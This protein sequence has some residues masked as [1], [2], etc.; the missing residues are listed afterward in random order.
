MSDW[1]CNICRYEEVK[2]NLPA[3]WTKRFGYKPEWFCAYAQDD[4]HMSG[5]CFFSIDKDEKVLT[6]H[7]ILVLSDNRRRGVATLL[8]RY[9]FDR[10]GKGMVCRIYHE[11]SDTPDVLHHF[12]YS[13]G[14][15]AEELNASLYYV[16]RTVWV[17][18]VLPRINL[19]AHRAI[20]TIYI[21][22]KQ[23]GKNIREEWRGKLDGS[24]VSKGLNPIYYV[25]DKYEKIFFHT[26]DGKDVGWVVVSQRPNNFASLDVI[27]IFPSFR[28]GGTV[29]S[30]Y[31][32]ITEFVFRTWP[33][34][35]GLYFQLDTQDIQLCRFYTRLLKDANYTCRKKDKYE[36]SL[37]PTT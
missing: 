10:Y 31:S 28:G 21:N 11:R 22:W 32:Q 12:L 37:F 13:L 27:Y 8:M 1:S 24:D 9:I 4:T 23:M 26:A 6:V 33:D 18:N 17:S 19:W 15:K 5:L 29:F 20:E 35:N 30:M 16:D 36:L 14:F 7:F 34:T 2:E 3:S 25:H